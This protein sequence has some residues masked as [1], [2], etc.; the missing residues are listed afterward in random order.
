M[1]P[2]LLYLAALAQLLWLPSQLTAGGPPWLCLPIDG[3]TADNAQAC[4]ALISAKL[5]HKL[6]PKSES[7]RAAEIH[8]DADQ[9]YLT[10]Y[11]QED[12]G[13]AEIEAALQGSEFSIPRERIRL[14]GHAILEIDPRKV[15]ATELVAALDAIDNVSIDDV[16]DRKGLLHATVQAPYPV[17]DNRPNPDNLSWETFA[18]NDYTSVA[19]NKSESPVGRNDLPSYEVFRHVLANHQASLKD[20]HWSMSHACRALGCVSAP[21]S[22]KTIATATK[23]SSTG[24]N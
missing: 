12:I 23:L 19:P 2:K 14:F 1:R 16:D 4:T 20:I 7:L 18:W 8:R 24:S 5:E 3:V 11:M 6:W 15:P 21:K 10:F 13:L 22:N 9:S 17:V